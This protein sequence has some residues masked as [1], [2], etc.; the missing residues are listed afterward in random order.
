MTRPITEATSVTIPKIMTDWREQ[1]PGPSL[2]DPA[3]KVQ[4]LAYVKARLDTD[5]VLRA[6]VDAEKDDFFNPEQRVRS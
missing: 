4:C 1:N 3:T 6:A 5:P 2:D